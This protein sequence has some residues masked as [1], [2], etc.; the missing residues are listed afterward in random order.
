VLALTAET[1]AALAGGRLDGGHAGAAITGVSIDTRKLE[2]G[3]LFVALKGASADGHDFLGDAIER[4]AG[5]LLVREGADVPAGAAAVRVPD[6][7]AALGALAAGVRGRLTARVVAI[8]GS[9]G[10]TITKEMTAAVAR[11][12]FRTIASEESFNNEIGVPLTVLAADEGTEVLVAEVGSR[13]VGHIATLMPVLRPDLGV[14]VNVGLAHVGMFGSAE[15]I[16][17]AKGELVESLPDDGAAILNADDPAVDA[18][19]SRT[20]ARVV[21]FGTAAAA[22]DVRAVDVSLADDASA[23]FTLVAPDGTA[24]VALRLRGEHM[25]VDALAAA[26]VGYALNVDVAAIAGAL[27]SV[28][29]TAWRMEIV[30]APG[31]WL[32]INDAYNANPAS[33]IA[34]L[35]ALVRMGRGARTWAVLGYMAELGDHEAAE[36]DRIGRLAVRLGVSRLVAVGRETRPMFEAAR[37]EGMTP[38]ELT[39]VAGAGEAI[40]M[41]RGALRPGDVVLVKASRAVGLERVAFAISGEDVA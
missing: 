19:A 6:T 14:V 36:H 40:A 13:G 9:S 4:G 31:G 30:D 38:E 29:A 10:K 21:R 23:S 26:A 12:R 37:L 39:M 8:T 16:A 33:T 20:S 18:M 5:A 11:T 27:S 32:V 41:L 35:K 7:E 15:A 3:G 25:I 34:A 28:S 2:K 17:V 24:R 1:I 22:A